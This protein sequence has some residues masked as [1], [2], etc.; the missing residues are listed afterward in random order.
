MYLSGITSSLLVRNNLLSSA[1]KLS[2]P[3]GA[4]AAPAEEPCLPCLLRWAAAGT[5]RGVKPGHAF[6]QPQKLAQGWPKPRDHDMQMTVRKNSWIA[7]AWD[8]K[9]RQENRNLGFFSLWHG[10]PKL[11]G[12]PKVHGQQRLPAARIL[13]ILQVLGPALQIFPVMGTEGSKRLLLG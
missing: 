4:S 10:V 5:H 3:H 13:N 7:P 6:S 1:A 8:C 11:R 2:S 12:F 9:H